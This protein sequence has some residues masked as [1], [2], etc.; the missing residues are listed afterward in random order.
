VSPDDGGS[1]VRQM[2]DFQVIAERDRV[3]EAIAALADQYRLLSEEM[4]RWATLRWMLPPRSAPRA[5]PGAGRSGNRD[6]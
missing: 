5:Y 3:A 2:D 6:A 1:D 4:A